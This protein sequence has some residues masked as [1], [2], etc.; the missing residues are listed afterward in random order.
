MQI[1]KSR[2]GRSVEHLKGNI[3]A[4]DVSLSRAEIDEIE[5]AYPFDIG[6]YPAMAIGREDFDKVFQGSRLINSSANFRTLVETQQRRTSSALNWDIR[7]MG[8]S[9]SRLFHL[10]FTS[11][12][13]TKAKAR[14]YLG[15]NVALACKIK[16]PYYGAGSCKL[17]IDRCSHR[18]DPLVRSW[19]IRTRMG[20]PRRKAAVC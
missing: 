13:S 17:G 9:C 15:E 11:E 20:R 19:Y 4:L 18:F 14:L 10:G 3:K 16:P 8:S 2:A 7:S 5:N 1:L 6:T 12:S